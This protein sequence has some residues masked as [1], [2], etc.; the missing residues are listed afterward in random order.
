MTMIPHSGREVVKSLC[1]GQSRGE[2][3]DQG[4]GA[5]F[6]ALSRALMRKLFSGKQTWQWKITILMGKLTINGHFH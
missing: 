1:Q 4:W 2:R 3:Y 5:G 6:L